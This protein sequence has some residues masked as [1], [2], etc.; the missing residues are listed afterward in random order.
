[1]T[2]PHDYL[3]AKSRQY[4]CGSCGWTGLGGDLAVIEAFAELA[5]YGCPRCD[6]KVAVLAFP[7]RSEIEAAA[8]RGDKAA[9]S[10]LRRAA[11]ADAHA[12]RVKASR[13]RPLQLPDPT[14][15]HGVHASLELEQQ[16]NHD[17]M[18][19]L[20]VNGVEV[21]REVAA[22]ESTEPAHRLLQAL[23][24]HY[25]NDLLSFDPWPAT[26]YLLGDRLNGASE[27]EKMVADLPQRDGGRR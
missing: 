13:E 27:L 8:D 24:D 1:M 18:L 20:L 5:E 4:T 6:S 15:G 2:D 22:F 25:G 7:L 10:M 17:A 14:E 26:L 16:A 19:V 3:A 23:K 11:D 9:W 21:R 12:A